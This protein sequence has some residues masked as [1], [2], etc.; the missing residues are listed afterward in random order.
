MVVA[1]GYRL[2]GFLDA[3]DVSNHAY[4]AERRSLLDLY[5]SAA[6]GPDRQF[7]IPS[8]QHI[9]IRLYLMARSESIKV[10]PKNM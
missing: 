8:Q 6:F 4:Y 9:Q 10:K 7:A 1:N 3:A 2:R 5:H